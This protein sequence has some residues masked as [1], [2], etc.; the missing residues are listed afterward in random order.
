MPWPTTREKTVLLYALIVCAAMLASPTA[1]AVKTATWVGAVGGGDGVSY[2]DL[3]N[4]DVDGLGNP[5]LEVPVNTLSDTYIV[6]LPTGN[7]V[8]FNVV[9]PLD[10]TKTFDVFQLTLASGS[11]L[12]VDPARKFNVVDAAAVSGRLTTAGGLFTALS[13][14]SSFGVRT[15]ARAM[16]ATACSIWPSSPSA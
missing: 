6:A 15:T 11:T 10:V 14:A 13:G 3:N 7:T 16:A 1:A 2:D 4:W 9:D 5:G 8:N 12:V